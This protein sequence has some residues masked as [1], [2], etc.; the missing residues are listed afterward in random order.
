MLLNPILAWGMLAGAIPV[1]IHL[2]FRTRY[3]RVAWAAMRWL[4]EAIRKNRRRL[5]IEQLILLL[6][7]ILA[8]SMLALA[9]ARPA[10]ADAAFYDALLPFFVGEVSVLAALF[11]AFFILGV[12]GAIELDSGRGARMI[13]G[14]VSLAAAAAVV[15]S[16]VADRESFGLPRGVALA[17]LVLGVAGLELSARLRRRF[18]GR[19]AVLAAAV[20]LAGAAFARWSAASADAGAAAASST[21]HRVILLDHSY[22]LALQ[23]GTGTVFD[24]A[25]RLAAALAGDKDPRIQR[26]SVLLAGEQTEVL[27]APGREFNP[28]AVQSEVEGVKCADVASNIPRVLKTAY[29]DFRAST[30][31]RQEIFLVTD[32]TAGGWL[33]ENG[34]PKDPTYIAAIRESLQ[35]REPGRPRP[36]LY[37][38]DVGAPEADRNLAV[39]DVRPELPVIAT[40]QIIQFTVRVHNHGAAPERGP[41]EGDRF[42]GIKVTLHVA[43]GLPPP[44][45]PETDGSDT[46]LNPRTIEVIDGH[47]SA[48]V[49]FAF[50]F[51]RPGPKR[52]WAT[53]DGDALPADDRRYLAVNVLPDL[54]VLVVNGAPSMD[55]TLNETFAL[56]KALN[57]SSAPDPDS[58]PVSVIRVEEIADSELADA[59]QLDLGRYALL[60]LADVGTISPTQAERLGDHVRSGGSVLVFLGDKVDRKIY[61]ERLF[62][63]DPDPKKAFHFLPMRLGE[64]TGDALG[65]A[66]FVTF[67]D[68]DFAHPAL[69]NFA[70]WPVL[71]RT[72]V[73]RYF[74]DASGVRDP[75]VRVLAR[76][77]DDARTPAILEREFAWVDADD[78]P[79]RGGRVM[80]FN[81]SASRNWNDLSPRPIFPPL[82][83]DVVYYLA[84]GGVRERNRLVGDTMNLDLPLEK[85]AET[86]R[87]L[88]PERETIDVRPHPRG[89]RLDVEF[90]DEKT[91]GRRAG[92]W[93]V[94]VGA[95]PAAPGAQHLFATNVAI[96]EGNLEHLA[97][98]RIGKLLGEDVPF[99]VITMADEKK[100][101]AALNLHSTFQPLHSDLII[102]VLAFLLVE[103]FL[104]QRFGGSLTRK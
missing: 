96:E 57:P 65:R 22:S 62:I 70:E 30:A 15:Y 54:P 50:Q 61:N 12:W 51:D 49:S 94:E 7:R 11:G 72:P 4:L 14:T 101:S 81:T 59:R 24:R 5:R 52:V 77:T 82:L 10:A 75:E 67:G 41:R 56:T 66:A 44:G 21:I 40:R 80:L 73:F 34:G 63:D 45:A 95:D 42:A 36:R 33:N 58:L 76:F 2:L 27:V 78:R 48:E 90:P 74:T 13:W 1:I 69:K 87:V 39:E 89:G 103:S 35:Q 99:E 28:A 17:V 9:L 18:I 26:L 104:A 31:A 20:V 93:C 8:V 98:D 19:L 86:V 47:S 16:G 46:V 97:A 43:D 100:V 32:L 6:L 60:V 38:L 83:H 3:R 55:P 84:H 88:T 92:F 29:D 25:R 85:V 68:L 37:I 79:R 71:Q 53:I 91:R 102:L 23:D 64:A